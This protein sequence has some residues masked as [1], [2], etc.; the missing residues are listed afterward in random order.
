MHSFRIFTNGTWTFSSDLTPIRPSTRLCQT[1]S[2][3]ESLKLGS[4]KVNNEN[5][6][7]HSI[8]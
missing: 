2:N 7:M 4:S 6:N 3:K 8:K 5:V 1:F